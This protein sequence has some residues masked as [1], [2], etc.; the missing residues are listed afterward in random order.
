MKQI[1]QEVESEFGEPFWDV[2]RGF[3]S[4]GYASGTTA[5]ILGFSG[6]DVFRRLQQR[7]GVTIDWPRHGQCN[8][9]KEPRG[10]YTK[11]RADKRL[12]AL[13]RRRK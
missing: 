6:Q 13:G 8:A 5:K 3:A 7:E 12:T 1:I 2:V 11:E 10:E 9:M 4:D